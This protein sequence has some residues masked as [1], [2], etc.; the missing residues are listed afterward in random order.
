MNGNDLLKHILDRLGYN[1]GAEELF[2]ADEVADWPPG[3]LEALVNVGLLRDVQPAR[4]I[5]C[6]GC[7][8]YCFMEVDVLL[9][10]GKAN[11]CTFIS[12][13]KR[14]AV[15][16][17]HVDPQRIKQWQITGDTLANSLATLLGFT[18]LPK[19]SSRQNCWTLGTLKGEQYRKQIILAINSDIIIEMSKHKV[20]LV[21]LLKFEKG[22]LVLDKEELYWLSLNPAPSTVPNRH[23]LC[24]AKREARKL[25]KAHPDKPQTWIA[26]RI[27]KMD[28]A[29]GAAPE[30]I[31]FFT[32]EEACRLF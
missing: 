12:C 31:V 16:S 23:Q 14:Y 15:G 2:R 20:P 9:T 21:E 32:C 18:D 8:E 29:G 28:I 6:D 19:K 1:G 22:Q 5:E 4:V 26:Q 27:S 10:E 24:D 7:E 11:K 17:V 25:E 13:D 30:T 3:I